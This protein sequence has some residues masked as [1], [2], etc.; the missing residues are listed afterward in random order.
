MNSPSEIGSDESFVLT[1][2]IDEIFHIYA[3]DTPEEKMA[4]SQEYPASESRMF[5]IYEKNDE[6]L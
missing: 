6:A 3:D 4:V 1:R 5:V 2:G